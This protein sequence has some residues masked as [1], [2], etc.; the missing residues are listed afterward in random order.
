MTNHSS[1][2]G[3]L[4]REMREILELVGNQDNGVP[5]G[6]SRCVACGDWK[7]RCLSRN[8]LEWHLGPG[9]VRCRCDANICSKCGEP[10]Y[11]YRLGSNVYDEDAG[12]VLHVPGMIGASHQCRLR[13]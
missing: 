5:K 13:K 12:R 2:F 9:P 3:N 10:I 7:G 4:P 8:P 1:R 11:T 6:L